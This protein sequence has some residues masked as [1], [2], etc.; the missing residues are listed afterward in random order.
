MDLYY[1][2]VPKNEMVKMI[3]LTNMQAEALLELRKY[4]D[5]IVMS[6]G[7][8]T[9]G[10]GIKLN[11]KT[12]KSLKQKGFIGGMWGGRN[13]RLTELGKTCVILKKDEE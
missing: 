8:L 9:G 6:D 1:T 4:P 2:F 10:H 3:K 13:N 11:L 5:V 7:W 12:V